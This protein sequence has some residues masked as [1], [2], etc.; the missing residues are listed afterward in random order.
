MRR[1]ASAK[2]FMSF[3]GLVPSENSSGDSTRRGP[4][5]RTGN[6]HLRR[7]LVEA[8]WSYRMA[9]NRS[10]TIRKRSCDVDPSIESIAWKAQERLH[11]VYK[12][13]MWRGRQHNVVVTAV[14]RQLA[15][16]IWAIGTA[17]LKLHAA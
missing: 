9:P 13:M 14:A 11:R 8:A 17:S 4:I 10:G 16:F 6:K 5:T 7:V 2:H 1:F 12:R 3:V 15:G